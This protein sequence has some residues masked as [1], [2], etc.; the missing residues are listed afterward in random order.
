MIS[1]QNQY[2]VALLQANDIPK[3]L[4]LHI[5]A[6]GTIEPITTGIPIGVSLGPGDGLAS[7]YQIAQ[8]LVHPGAGAVGIGDRLIYPA[9]VTT[10]Y[11]VLPGNFMPL[12]DIVTGTPFAFAVALEA[13]LTGGGLTRALLIPPFAFL[14]PIP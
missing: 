7:P 8:C 2:L 3:G 14:P 5:S 13:H 1:A 9:D 10:A 4:C 6:A 12:A 11:G